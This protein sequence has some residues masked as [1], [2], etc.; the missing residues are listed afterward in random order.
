MTS[1]ELILQSIELIFS[2]AASLSSLKLLHRQ[3]KD[4]GWEY[5]EVIVVVVVLLALSRLVSD[6][7]LLILL[8]RPSCIRD[9]TSSLRTEINS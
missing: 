8:I 1:V 9:G 2:T 4:R 3:I 6:I 5:N 7:G